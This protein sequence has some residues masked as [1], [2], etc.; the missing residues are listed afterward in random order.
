MKILRTETP[1]VL[2]D[3]ARA[4]DEDINKPVGLQFPS[5]SKGTARTARSRIKSV[6]TSNRADAI[7][8]KST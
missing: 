7:L 2:N 5:I 6:P 3:R 8:N 4:R 1:Y